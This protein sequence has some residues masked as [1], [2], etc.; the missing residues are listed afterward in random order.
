V[1]ILVLDIPTSSTADQSTGVTSKLQV[2]VRHFTCDL[3][4]EF[5]LFV[6]CFLYMD[7][8]QSDS[9]VATTTTAYKY[10]PMHQHI[11]SEKVEVAIVVVG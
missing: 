3:I 4:V 11:Q 8:G 9:A 7:N 10:Y 6:I 5:A 1:V 2:Q